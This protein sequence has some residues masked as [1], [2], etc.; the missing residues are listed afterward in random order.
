[1]GARGPLPKPTALRLLEGNPSGKPIND[2]EPRPVALPTLDPPDDLGPIARDVWAHNAKEL[3]RLGLLTTIDRE[4]F[5]RYCWTAERWHLA[6]QK[7]ES[8][9]TV[10]PRMSPDG[11]TLISLIQNPYWFIERS[12]S[13]ELSRFEQAFGMT[14]SARTRFRIEGGTGGGGA[15]PDADPFD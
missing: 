13:Q 7:V 10:I 12:Y 6:R 9:G 4:A 15:I 11:K 2:A 1:M 5:Y 8:M 3:D 14:P